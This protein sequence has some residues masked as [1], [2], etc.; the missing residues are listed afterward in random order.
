MQ[1][2]STVQYRVQGVN[3]STSLGQ[4]SIEPSLAPS[5]ERSYSL[6]SAL[7]GVSVVSYFCPYIISNGGPIVASFALL[8]KQFGKSFL[9]QRISLFNINT[10]KF[11]Q[12]TRPCGVAAPGQVVRYSSR[13]GLFSAQ[14]CRARN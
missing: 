12:Q 3:G 11:A 1:Q 10:E 4:L 6:T 7:T 2:Y 13:R 8:L 5:I 14:F 9:D